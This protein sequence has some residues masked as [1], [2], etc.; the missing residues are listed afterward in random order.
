MEITIF[1]SFGTD[2]GLVSLK[3][4]ANAV[5][6]SLRYFSF[7]RATIGLSPA[8]FLPF[9]TMPNV[10]PDFFAYRSLVPSSVTRKPT[11]VG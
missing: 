10:C 6:T 11:R 2:I 1:S 3:R 9:L 5:A 7:A 8:Y 4:S